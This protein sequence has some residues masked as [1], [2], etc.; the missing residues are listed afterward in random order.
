[1]SDLS[2]VKALVFDVF[3]TVVD[4]R[5]SLINDFSKWGETRGIKADWTA[6]VDGWRAVYAASMD[7]VRKNPQNG[8]VILDV[9]HRRSLEKLVAQFDIK[10]LTEAD[11]QH[12]T[13]GWHRLHG[14]PDSVAGLTRLKTK[15]IISPLSNGN[16]A[17]LT[18]MAKFAGLPWDLVMSAELFEHYKPDPETYLGAAKLLCLPPEQVMMVAAHNYDLKHAQ[19]HGLK[20]A[21]VARPQEYGPLQKYDFEATGQWDIVAK[22]FGE[23]ADRMGC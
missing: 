9:L 6:L 15:Y 20:T 8:Y 17:L 21:F 10:G 22:D 2:A 19:K 5:T 18:N 14:W 4:W 3:G 11:L 16:V 13:T 12:L 1:M 7:E 23:I